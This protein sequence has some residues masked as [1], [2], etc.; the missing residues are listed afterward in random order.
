M[1]HPDA[2]RWNARYEAE[3]E[4]WLEREPRRLLRL[5]SHLLPK[6]GLALDAAAG[7][8]TNSLFLARR[9]LRIIAL[10]ISLV[11]SQMAK[12]RATCHSLPV[13]PAVYDL[14]DPWLPPARFDVIVNFNFLERATFSIYR[15]ALK[16]GGILFFETFLK[17]NSDV[18][19][20]DYYLEPGELRAAF[21]D[22]EII[23]WSESSVSTQVPHLHKAK[24]QLIARKPR[25]LGKSPM[26]TH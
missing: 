1:S 4:A 22:F 7:V 10:D 19:D 13:F 11:A 23:H 8:G 12:Q 3:R 24:A 15:E 17:I 2:L 21:R 25:F 18:A 16:P 6:E 20:P 14:K 5:Y 26:Y 9:G